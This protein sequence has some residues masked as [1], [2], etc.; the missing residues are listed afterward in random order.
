MS[1]R[2]TPECERMR[3]Q[4]D[5]N[6]TIEVQ[7]DITDREEGYEDDIRF[8]IHESGPRE[9]RMFRFDTTS[10]LLTPAQAEQLARALIQA[11]QDSR[12]IPR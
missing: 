5:E 1:S 4:V 3:I 11:A 8:A 10:F 2:P 9:V 7:F 12:S 6:I